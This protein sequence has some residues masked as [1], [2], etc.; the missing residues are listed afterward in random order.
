MLTEDLIRSKNPKCSDIYKIQKLN[1]CGEDIEDISIISKMKNLTILS[2]S[3]NNISDLS[4]LESCINLRE[5]YLR[6]NNISSFQEITHLK[7][8]LKLKI[9]WLEGN[10]ISNDPFYRYKVFRILPQVSIFDKNSDNENKS[11]PLSTIIMNKEKLNYKPVKK[12]YRRILL[13]IFYCFLFIALT[14]IV[15]QV[16]QK[17]IYCDNINH[18]KNKAVKYKKIKI[19]SDDSFHLKTKNEIT[20]KY[21]DFWCNFDPE[22]FIIHKIL[23]KKYKIKI[24]YDDNPQI[25]PDYVIYSIFGK[26]YKKYNCTKIYYT[27]EPSVPNFSE[28]NYSIG[29]RFLNIPNK[30]HF[31]NPINLDYFLVKNNLYNI[32]IS[33][34]F[35]IKNRKFCAWLVSNSNCK[36]R[37]MFYKL[38]SKYKKIDSGG[39]FHNNIGFKVKNKTDFFKNYKF[40]IVF[41]NS[42][43][44]GYFTEKFRDALSSGTIPIYWGDDSIL[45][46]FNFKS[47]IHVKD[48]KEFEEKIKYII[49]IDQ[50]DTLYNEIIHEKIILN[51]NKVNN[52]KQ[53]ENFLYDIFDKN[54]TKL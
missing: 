47:Y 22:D 5:L 28:C 53:F 9:L 39:D 32:S 21:S 31:R 14:L 43:Y 12:N 7:N 29:L 2:L 52:M 24:L 45:D 51:E 27:F 20:I 6:K 33:N 48:R 37:N 50:N 42:K 18:F 3:S 15:F 49:K 30:R 40:A 44:L 46:T 25:K 41:E 36:A 54:K 10:P 1:I 17:L 35:K 4:P 23:S 34:G 19:H 11:I 8:L 38:L 26:N 13:F 16:I